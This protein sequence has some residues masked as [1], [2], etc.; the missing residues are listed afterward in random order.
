MARTGPLEDFQFSSERVEDRSEQILVRLEGDRFICET[1]PLRRYDRSRAAFF[2]R[3]WPDF[4]RPAPFSIPLLEP[5]F[6]AE[7]Q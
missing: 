6:E 2:E 7:H 3:D 1:R 4:L 5:E